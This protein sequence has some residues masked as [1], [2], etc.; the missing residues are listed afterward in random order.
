MHKTLA[1]YENN[2]KYLSQRYESAKKVHP[3]FT[4]KKA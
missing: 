3:T 4:P 1:Y 2:A